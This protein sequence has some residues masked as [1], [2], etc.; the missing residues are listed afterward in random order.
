MDSQ[1]VHH[2]DHAGQAGAGVGATPVAWDGFT[3]LPRQARDP[4]RSRRAGGRSRFWR[5]RLAKWPGSASCEV[6]KP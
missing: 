3:S 6:I 5:D 4:E 2:S 1:K